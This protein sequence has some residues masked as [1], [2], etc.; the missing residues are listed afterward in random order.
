M[1]YREDYQGAASR[2]QKS[3][4]TGKI[5]ATVTAY[6]GRFL[7]Q[8]EMT[9]EWKNVGEQYAREKVSH[10]L[11][12]AKDP[13]RPKIKKPREVKRHIPTA[14]EDRLFEMT[15]AD[16]QQIFRYLVINEAK[17]ITAE[18]RLDDV[19]SRFSDN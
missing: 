12:S 16:Q 9:G 11:R 7:K 3:F 1:L 18:I 8:D 13:N 2:E 4:I 10:A 17:G 15:Y 19:T 6:G 5:V 14:E